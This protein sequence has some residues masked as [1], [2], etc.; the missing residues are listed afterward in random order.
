[1]TPTNATF[2]PDLETQY[3]LEDLY[4]KNQT[5]PRL[6]QEFDIPE[7]HTHCDEHDIPVNF[8]VD[9]LAQM[10]LHKRTT[11]STL[12]GILHKHFMEDP[13]QVPTTTELQACSDMVL[14]AAEADLMD[15]DALATQFVFRID[16]SEDVYADLE[17][18]QY[19]LPLV[20]A[21]KEVCRNHDTGYHS[22]D[23]RYGS[24]LLKHNHHDDDICLDHINRVNGVKL[25]INPNTVA[26]IQNR[27]RDL[28]HQKDGE[29][30]EDYTKRVKAFEKYD[31]SSRDVIAHLLMLGNEF[32]L[33]HRY[34]KRGRC[35]AQGYH[36]NPQ[37]ND[38]SKA[39]VEFVE[40]ELVSGVIQE[41]TQERAAA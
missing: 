35:Y 25:C 36:V 30:R 37:G 40:K 20:V 1:M 4:N 32:H 10:V 18:Y 31:R 17:R 21:P 6:R 2:A 24:L 29:S 14:K 3:V 22:E 39:V 38:W 23:S 12:V 13:D 33:T 15:W 19:P 28:D 34:D 9:L 41:P 11:V 26:M 16:V 5:L 27:W 7:I 8:A